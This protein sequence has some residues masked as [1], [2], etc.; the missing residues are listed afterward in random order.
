MTKLAIHG[1]D[2]VSLEPYLDSVS[3][4]LLIKTK[5]FI[6]DTSV[7][8]GKIYSVKRFKRSEAFVPPA[9]MSCL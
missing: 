2:F 9:E 4:T 8:C 5:M 6:A 1:D 7:D 3:G